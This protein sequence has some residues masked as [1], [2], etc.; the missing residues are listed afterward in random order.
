MAK[1]KERDVLDV[2]EKERE[3]VILE[4]LLSLNNGNCNYPD[5]NSRV[6]LAIE[7]YNVFI[8]KV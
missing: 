7:M 5:A 8:E 2:L 4:I 6:E 3:E 1:D